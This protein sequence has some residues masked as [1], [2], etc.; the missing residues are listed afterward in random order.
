[1]RFDLDAIDAPLGE[2]GAPRSIALQDIDEDPEQPR[3]EFDDAS[4]RELAAT[5]AERGVKQPV[6]VRPHPTEPGRW[7]LNFGARRL[8]AARL[9]GLAHIPAF[10]DEAADSYDQVIENEQREGLKPLEMAMFVKRRMA[11]G[12]SQAE[13]ARRLG[14]SPTLITMIST[15]IDPPPWLLAAYRNGQCKGVTELYEL[16]RLYERLPDRALELAAQGVPIT[17]EVLQAARACGRGN[18]GGSTVLINPTGEMPKPRTTR[19]K[20]APAVARKQ[21]KLLARASAQCDAL[22]AVVEQMRE[23]EP[24]SLATLSERLAD[25]R[26]ACLAR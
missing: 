16:R 5:L 11:A 9:A 24:E 20:A 13:I 21:T 1:M 6:S 3:S 26:A 10:V 4:L 8:R 12:E 14:K 19:S 17:R 2:S 22:K 23:C 15:M 7:M 18:E 25:L